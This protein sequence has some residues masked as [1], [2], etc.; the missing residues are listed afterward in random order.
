MQKPAAGRVQHQARRLG[1]ICFALGILL[2]ATGCGAAGPED[3]ASAD[4]QSPAEST[5]VVD[6][7]ALAAT[8]E[9]LA[10][11]MRLPGAVMMVHTP[12]IDL[13]RTYG[14]TGL[15]SDRQTAP[16]DHYRV[17]SLT[18]TMTGTVILQLAQE[19][20][21]SLDDPIS[22]Y[23]D[24]VPGGD[25]I[26][27]TELLNM[28]S[29][30]FNYTLTEELN[31]ALDE[32]PDRAWN[33]EELVALG[34]SHPVSFAPGE[35]WEYSNTNTVILG[36]V[37]EQVEGKPL[38]EIFTERLFEPLGMTD[39]F[40]PDSTDR[41]MPEPFAHGY[42]YGTNMETIESGELPQEVQDE[43]QAGTLTP[44]DLTEVNPSWGWAAGAV[45]STGSDMLKW[46]RALTDGSLLDAEYQQLRIDSLQST[47]DDPAGAQYGLGLARFGPLYGHTGE[48]PGYNNFVGSDPETGAAVVIWANL[49]PLPDGR[50]PATTIARD[51]IALLYPPTP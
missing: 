30:L 21:V 22:K 29:G 7:D 41:H 26:T 5:L 44:N 9:Q 1:A 40:L 49:A 31:R 19:G 28:R 48:L 10:E 24:D 50:S 18:K 3:S 43:W 47:S 14:T 4:N 27:L 23:R 34:L 11:D 38:N 45:V 6:A 39:T 2:A 25:E 36:L 17:G 37:A 51:L 15:D 46:A 13:V 20:L 12:E 32:Q 35:A 8:F 33:P 42:A 16:D